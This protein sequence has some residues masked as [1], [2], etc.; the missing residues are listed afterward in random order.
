MLSYG[1]CI[2]SNSSILSFRVLNKMFSS[3]YDLYLLVKTYILTIYIHVIVKILLNA[4]II[5]NW[6]YV[7]IYSEFTT[8][9]P[10]VCVLR[11]L[12]FYR[13]KI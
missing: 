12:L 10:G 4:F 8:V 1:R 9:L 11:H 3:N 2:E 7:D 13:N 5:V 6:C